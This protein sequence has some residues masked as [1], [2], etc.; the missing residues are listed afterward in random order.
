VRGLRPWLGR[1]LLR[2]VALLPPT[3]L[4]WIWFPSF[5]KCHLLSRKSLSSKAFWL[6]EPA[7][8][9]I[10]GY[11]LSRKTLNISTGY[12]TYLIV[13]SEKEKKGLS[14]VEAV[15]MLATPQELSKRMGATLSVVPRSGISISLPLPCCIALPQRPPANN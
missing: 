2:L 4:M 3:L 1:P 5:N 11:S 8:C 9:N 10:M 6:R 12:D 15:G 7:D 13:S 14:L